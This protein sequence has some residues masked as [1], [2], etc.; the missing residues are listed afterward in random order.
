MTSEA[1]ILAAV[2]AN[3]WDDTPRLAFADFL[4]DHDP[5]RAEFIRVQVELARLGPR[6]SGNCRCDGGGTV[7][8]TCRDER[9]WDEGAAP[10]RA[11][12][13]E[14]FGGW[15]R[16]WRFGAGWSCVLDSDGIAGLND[17]NDPNEPARPTVVVRRG[18]PATARLTLAAFWGG[19]CPACEVEGV[20]LG[21]F[22]VPNRECQHCHNT[23]L[24]NRHRDGG[25]EQWCPRC[26]S[27]VV[28]Q[29]TDVPCT[30]CSGTG[31]LPGLAARLGG[32]VG[33]VG[34]EL[35]DREPLESRRAN[36][37]WTWA[38]VGLPAGAPASDLPV[39]VMRHPTLSK[40]GAARS[41]PDRPAA[42]AA[43]SAACLGYARELAGVTA[44][45]SEK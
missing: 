7:C 11:R 28:P 41:F 21:S 38:A 18:F 3:P 22:P 10:L 25:L 4:D 14:L 31:H 43:L 16:W 44:P 27:V 32:V 39:E 26:M 34:V 45:A 12:E 36:W 5:A 40:G 19:E 1:A 35:V 23:D 37:Y 33:L 2:H 9:D 13:R 42:L 20:S 15:R 30:S 24:R 8:G 17:P 6:P 29:S